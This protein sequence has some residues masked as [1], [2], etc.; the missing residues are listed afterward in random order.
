MKKGKF[1]I[2][3]YLSL[4]III[5]SNLIGATLK[6]NFF[7]KDN[8]M[9]V[10]DSDSTKPLPDRYRDI[11]TLN[12][13]GSAQFTPSQVEPLK[14]A[15]NKPS[16]CIVDLRQESHGSINDYAISFFDPYKLLNNGFTTLE[17]IE[18]ENEELDRIKLGSNVNIFHRTGR[19]FKAV[20]VTS[21]S[22]E[23][24]I[25]VK[26]DIQYK[27]FAVKD[28]GIPTPTIVDEFVDFIKNKPEDLHLHFHCDAGEGR[29]TSFMAMYQIM[30]NPNNLSLDQIL[31]YQ[32]N[33]GGIILTND[34]YRAEFLNEFYNYVNQNKDTNYETSYSEWVKQ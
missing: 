5:L 1:K 23:E 22:N 34:K 11:P 15:I 4:F 21:V 25:V 6:P 31:T 12:I 10:L 33:V 9:I 16:I 20:D 8:T 28:N 17:T 29:T 3:L 27:R 30:V 13:S 26:C 19:L 24:S 14:K 7:F 18:K 2:I 32:Y